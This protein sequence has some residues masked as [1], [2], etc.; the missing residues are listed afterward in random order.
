MSQERRKVSYH[1]DWLVCC[2]CVKDKGASISGMNRTVQERELGRGRD[3]IGQEMPVFPV[4]YG[5]PHL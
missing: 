1:C 4:C 2:S 3:R 5:L